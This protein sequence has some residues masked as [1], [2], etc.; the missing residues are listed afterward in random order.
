MLFGDDIV[1]KEFWRGAHLWREFWCFF[2]AYKLRVKPKSKESH[3][4][5]FKVQCMMQ[6]ICLN[7]ENYWGTWIKV[8]IYE[9]ALGF[10]GK[11]GNEL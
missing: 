6:N 7:C 9:Q 2:Y 3:K 11:N 5:L 1:W 4:V 10:Q 8:S